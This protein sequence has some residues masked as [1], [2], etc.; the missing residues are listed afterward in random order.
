MTSISKTRIVCSIFPPPCS[1]SLSYH[2]ANVAIA[3]INNGIVDELYAYEEAKTIETKE[4]ANCNFPERSLALGFKEL[5]IGPEDIDEWVFPSL[6]FQSSRSQINEFLTNIKAKKRSVNENDYNVKFIPHSLL[7][8]HAAVKSS[9]YGESYIL[10]H[11][12]GGDIGDK[13]DYLFGYYNGKNIRILEKTNNYKNI[14]T[15]HRYITELLG[16]GGMSSN[17]KTSGLAAYGNFNEEIIDR[18]KNYIN[19]NPDNCLTPEVTLSIKKPSKTNFSSVD[20]SN[21]LFDKYVN[22]PPANTG[23]LSLLDDFEPQDIAASMEELLSRVI[24]DLIFSLQN[25]YPEIQG[26][27]LCVSGGLFNNVKLN[28]EIMDTN[29]FSDVFFSMNAGDSGLSLGGVL[30]SSNGVSNSLK[31]DDGCLMPYLGPSFDDAYIDKLIDSINLKSSVH[32]KSLDEICIEIKNGAVVGIFE[33]RA[34]FGPRSL[35]NRSIVANPADPNSKGRVNFLVKKRD[36]FMP[37]APAILADHVNNY[38]DQNTASSYMQ[39][40]C[41]IN[42][43]HEEIKSGIHVD[44]T[45]RIQKVFTTDHSIFSKIIAKFQEVSGVPCLLNTSFN[46][47][48]TATISSPE[49]ALSLLLQ[50]RIDILLINGRF[51]KITN[52]KSITAHNHQLEKP[53]NHLLADMKDEIIAKRG[54]NNYMRQ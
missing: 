46:K 39:V 49:Q 38:T 34:E 10:V 14:C 37:F 32:N 51:L 22:P 13:T 16:W 26:S 9:G 47:H 18:L 6:Q 7:H 23:L 41:K 25:K 5:N 44:G 4:F 40:A 35:G 31:L 42:N 36:W 19:E 11:D 33:G 43:K 50:G 45:S 30:S 8:A 2:D 28:R 53:L 20:L 12:G 17:G 21:F 48:G 3:K 29:V 54:N 24:K 52:R 27:K 1:G 15:L